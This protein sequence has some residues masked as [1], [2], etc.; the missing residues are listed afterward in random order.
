MLYIIYLFN[1]NLMT[2]INFESFLYKSLRCV[3][4]WV[5]VGVYKNK[6]S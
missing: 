2:L 4:Y 3:Y 1:M 6:D 5:S